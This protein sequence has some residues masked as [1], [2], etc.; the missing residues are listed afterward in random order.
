MGEQQQQQ[1]PAKKKSFLK[2]ALFG[3]NGTAGEL[4]KVIYFSACVVQTDKG[5]EQQAIIIYGDE[6]S[7]YNMMLPL[8]SIRL[9]Y[10]NDLD[11]AYIKINRSWGGSKAEIFFPL[12]YS[13]MAPAMGAVIAAM[14]QP[15]IQQ[16]ATENDEVEEPIFERDEEYTG[17]TYTPD[18]VMKT[19]AAESPTPVAMDMAPD[20]PQKKIRDRDV[21]ADQDSFSLTFDSDALNEKIDKFM[22]HGGPPKTVNNGRST[23]IDTRT[24]D[25]LKQEVVQDEM[26]RLTKNNSRF[27]PED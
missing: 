24:I 1:K 5:L 27:H 13:F 7:I 2:E 3:G 19:V 21:I 11:G 10:N 25:E 20:R 22:K 9:S 6:N 4:Y 8:M 17:P 26:E 14:P 12:Q 15:V 16:V 18:D 23:E